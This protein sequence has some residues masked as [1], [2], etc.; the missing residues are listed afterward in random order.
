MP[1][2]STKAESFSFL[3]DM[4]ESARPSAT[5]SRQTIATNGSPRKPIGARQEEDTIVVDE[6]T[7][8]RLPKVIALTG[9]SKSTLYSM[10]QQKSFPSSILLGRRTVAWLKSEVEQWISER[11]QAS[12]QART[13]R[14]SPSSSSRRLRMD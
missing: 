11:I 8:L 3:P 1:G 13:I 7:F 14:W 6:Q 10:I 12:R 5:S 2:M 4:R 9:L